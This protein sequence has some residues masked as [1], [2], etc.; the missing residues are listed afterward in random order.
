MSPLGVMSSVYFY[1][2]ENALQMRAHRPREI[3]MRGLKAPSFVKKTEKIIY[4]HG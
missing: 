2:V 1:V 4:E 3:G